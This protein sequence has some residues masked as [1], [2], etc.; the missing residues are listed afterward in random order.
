MVFRTSNV[1]VSDLE[2]DMRMQCC[3]SSLNIFYVFGII[4]SSVTLFPFFVFM[5]FGFLI[6]RVF[7]LPTRF[8]GTMSFLFRWRK[9]RNDVFSLCLSIKE[10]MYAFRNDLY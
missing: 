3:Y 10:N 4:S 9:V 2:L 8:V 1:Y 6:F 7:L 5:F